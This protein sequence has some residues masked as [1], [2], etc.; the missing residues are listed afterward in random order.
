VLWVESEKVCGQEI[1]VLRIPRNFL[2]NESGEML[3]WNR[4]EPL[5]VMQKELEIEL[6]L[7]FQSTKVTG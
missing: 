3:K 4:V 5:M 6:C 1:V 2:G 7:S